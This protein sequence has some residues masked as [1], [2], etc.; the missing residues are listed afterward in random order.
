MR[1]KS[2]GRKLS[3]FIC[4]MILCYGV[5]WGGSL[6]VATSIDT[7]YM[8][9][10]KPA[11]NPPSIVFPIVW[12]VLY[13][14]IGIALWKILCN[15]KAYK[16]RVIGVFLAQLFLNFSWTFSF[17][18]L[19]STFFGLLNILL[20]FVFIAW[21]IF[22]CYPYSKLSA[23]LLTPYFLWVGYATALN[24]NIWYFN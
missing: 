13:T 20:L 23:A 3:L 17:F 19:Q 6:F 8:T 1:D 9:L 5:E 10:E 16:V 21:N 15:S 12:T 18:Y 14:M 4:S 7:W 24:F 2:R 11:W 22:V